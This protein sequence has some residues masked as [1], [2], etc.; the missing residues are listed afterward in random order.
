VLVFATIVIAGGCTMPFEWAGSQPD[1]TSEPSSDG[2][3][4]GDPQDQPAPGDGADYQDSPQV[5]SIAGT[6]FILAW[7][8][9]ATEVVAHRVYFREYGTSEW[10]VLADNVASPQ[11]EVSASDLAYGTY[12]FAVSSLGANG[13]ESDLHYSFDP[14]A[15]PEPWILEWSAL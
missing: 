14:T 9:D 8:A 13:M 1:S 6:E 15:D 5:L 4:D 12:E 7:D 10:Q 2:G 11:H 3:S